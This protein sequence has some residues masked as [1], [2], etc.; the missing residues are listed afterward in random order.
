MDLQLAPWQPCLVWGSWQEAMV[1]GGG[2]LPTSHSFRGLFPALRTII[3]LG[4]A[5]MSLHLE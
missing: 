4:P 5:L 3:T 2:R 1:P